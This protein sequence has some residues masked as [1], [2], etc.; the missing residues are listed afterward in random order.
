MPAIPYQKASEAAA[1]TVG[2][3][4][5][6]QTHREAVESEARIQKHLDTLTEEAWGFAGKEWAQSKSPEHKRPN[7]SLNVCTGDAVGLK[8]ALRELGYTNV[9]EKH[10][11]ECT[12]RGYEWEAHSEIRVFVEV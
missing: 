10:V 3:V 6:E 7:I 1:V 4:R 5:K 12:E 9:T 8:T 2:Y 11:P